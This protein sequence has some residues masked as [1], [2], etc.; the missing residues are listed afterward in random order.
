MSKFNSI[1][2]LMMFFVGLCTFSSAVAQVDSDKP[3]QDTLYI[4][5]EE[6]TYDTLYVYDSLPDPELMNKEDLL[7]AFRQDRGIG[8]LYYQRGNLYLIGNEELYRL[9]D[10]DLKWFLAAAEYEQW[11]KAKRDQYLSITLYALSGGAVVVSAIGFAQ[12]TASFILSAN[13]DQITYSSGLSHNLWRSAMGGMLLFGGGAVVA[14][15]LWRPA[16][17]LMTKSKENINNIVNNFNTT[18]NTTALELRAGP[19]PGGFGI[20]LSF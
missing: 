11:R 10:S 6:Y 15:A 18:S 5:E 16:A 2:K 17:K 19:T 8:K 20:T 9:D 13:R 3:A 1:L 7:K 12:F 4:I 14:G